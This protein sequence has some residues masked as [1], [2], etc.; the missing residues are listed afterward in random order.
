MAAASWNF[1][2][3][4][5]CRS[6]ARTG[7]LTIRDYAQRASL[8]GIWR[9]FSSM[10]N[11]SD[12]GTKAGG[13]EKYSLVGAFLHLFD[14]FGWIIKQDSEWKLTAIGADNIFRFQRRT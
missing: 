7:M 11:D 14:E 2:Q 5:A 9:L 1:A 13:Q 12:A 4:S 10:N 3:G 6:I 8:L